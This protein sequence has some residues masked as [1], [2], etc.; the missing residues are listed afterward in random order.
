MSDP[1]KECRGVGKK[2]E[3]ELCEGNG[4]VDDPEDGGTMVCPDC[5]GEAGINCQECEG[6][7]E[8]IPPINPSEIV[9]SQ[10]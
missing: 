2:A 10:K 9:G 1:C 6:S 8:E 5:D 3:C 4:W 7:G